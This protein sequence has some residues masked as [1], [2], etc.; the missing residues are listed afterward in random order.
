V[1]IVVTKKE[2]KSEFR[3]RFGGL[4][5]YLKEVRQVRIER[6]P[7]RTALYRAYRAEKAGGKWTRVR[8]GYTISILSMH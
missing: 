8:V 1:V 7:R 5:S 6:G 4:R 3:S 2:R